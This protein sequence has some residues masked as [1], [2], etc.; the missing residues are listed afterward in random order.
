MTSGSPPVQVVEE[1]DLTEIL[2]WH[3]G[4]GG[5]FWGESNMAGYETKWRLSES[6]QNMVATPYAHLDLLKWIWR[7]ILGNPPRGSGACP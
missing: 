4:M 3:G 6:F 2:W 7:H 1:L 5:K